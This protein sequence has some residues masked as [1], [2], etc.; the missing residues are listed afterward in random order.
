MHQ[1][2]P[3]SSYKGTCW[4]HTELSDFRQQTMDDYFNQGE[5][6]MKAS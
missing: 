1:L 4:F 2:V 3:N 5:Q 6:G